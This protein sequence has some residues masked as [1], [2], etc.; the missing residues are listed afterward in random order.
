K[1]GRGA[2]HTPDVIADFGAAMLNVGAA[3]DRQIGEP[4]AGSGNMWRAEAAHLRR[5]GKDPADHEWIGVEIDPLSAAVLAANALLWGLG[6]GV[7]IACADALTRDSGL[8]QAYE[9]RDRAIAAAMP[10]S[11]TSPTSRD[12]LLLF[13]CVV[14]GVLRGRRARRRRANRSPRKGQTL[15][16]QTPGWTVVPNA[17]TGRGAMRQHFDRRIHPATLRPLAPDFRCVDCVFVVFRRVDDG[18]PRMKCSR[19]AAR[20]RGPDLKPDFP[21]CDAYQPAPGA[22]AGPGQD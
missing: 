15:M 20:R 5:L 12:C 19:K 22:P 1:S 4:A 18:P 9:E 11:S 2:F 21:A 14:W 3:G 7:V 13:S 16:N 10:W 17:A 8:T 6:D